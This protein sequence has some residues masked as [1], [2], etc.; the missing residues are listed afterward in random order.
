M[1]T[2]SRFL[3]KFI[4]VHHAFMLRHDLG[5]VPD[6]PVQLEGL[7]VSVYFVPCTLAQYETWVRACVEI[8]SLPQTVPYR[9]QRDLG[10][11]VFWTTLGHTRVSCTAVSTQ[12]DDSVYA[13]LL[14]RLLGVIPTSGTVFEGITET[15]L[16][17]RRKGVYAWQQTFQLRFLRD[18][19]FHHRFSLEMEDQE[20]PRRVQERNGAVLVGELCLIL[21]PA[22]T[23]SS[24]RLSAWLSSPR[25]VRA[26]P[27]I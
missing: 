21:F 8:P 12:V 7:M 9:G 19:G 24:L 11:I 6:V 25:L 5:P 1:T 17:F 23:R 26:L 10:T 3:S 2:L 16:Q 15:A 18:Y 14:P 27:A 4:R 13:V 20:G 22:F